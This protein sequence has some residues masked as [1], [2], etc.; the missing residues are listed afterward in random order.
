MHSA[1]LF[2]CQVHKLSRDPRRAKEIFW[3]ILCAVQYL[4]SHGIIHRDIKPTNILLKVQKDDSRWAKVCDLGL[5]I[6]PETPLPLVTT[7]C[8]TPDYMAPEMLEKHRT[9]RPSADIY[10]LGALLF[11]MM[12]GERPFRTTKTNRSEI[13]RE[14]KMQE[15]AFD[16]Y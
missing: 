10:S 7:F 12:T 3:Q 9:I 4:H 13:E 1:I 14:R 8:G 11:T 15:I 5:A 16:R 6:R 2:F